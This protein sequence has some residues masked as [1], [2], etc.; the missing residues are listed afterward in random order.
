M[1]KGNVLITGAGKRVGRAIALSLA[2]EGWTVAAHYA[3]SRED[4]D[5]LVAEIIAGGGKAAAV[6]ANLAREEE[7]AALVPAA[8]RA[9]GPL[10][11]LINNASSFEDDRVES[12]TR[13]SWDLHMEINLRAPVALAQAFAAQLPK[14]AT[15]AIVNMID[16]RVLR[17]N[18]KFF[19][20]AI[21]K[22]ALFAAT[23]TLA[24]GLAPA[25]RVNAIGPGPTLRNARQSQADFDRQV[26]ATLLER[27]SP[28]DE[29][30]EAVRYLLA[31]RSVTGQMIAVDGGQHLAWETPDVAGLT[32]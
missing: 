26:K 23:R 32:E 20:Y 14:G 12:M 3:S 11:A 21:S 25:I 7:T 28:P 29:I 1:T 18:P 22:A 31:A 10:T 15:G 2:S 9:L 30:C 27:G 16:Q 19:T 17:P 6:G 4:A 5:S 13:A 8:V 24:Q